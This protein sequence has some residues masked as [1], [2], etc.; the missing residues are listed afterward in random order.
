VADNVISLRAGVWNKEQFS[1]A[2]GLF[3]RTL[4]L[5][6]VGQIGLE[7]I[8]R[9]RGFG[10]PVVAWSRSLTPQRAAELGIKPRSSPEEV[11]READIVSVHW[12]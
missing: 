5:I 10:L 7:M 8:P 1:K 2:R 6:G 4:G 11:A 9:A 12:R 3:G